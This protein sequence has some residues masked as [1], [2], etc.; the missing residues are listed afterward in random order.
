VLEADPGEMAQVD[1]ATAIVYLGGTRTTVHLF[2]MRMKYS[3][4]PFV[5][6]AE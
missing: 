6:A 4:V 3:K 2:C 1:W 5:W